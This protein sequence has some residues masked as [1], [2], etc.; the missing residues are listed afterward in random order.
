MLPVEQR[1]ILRRES[2]RSD[3]VFVQK[4]DNDLKF[5][6]TGQCE[7]ALRMNGSGWKTWLKRRCVVQ[8]QGGLGSQEPGGFGSS[9]WRNLEQWFSTGDKLF[10]WLPK[11]SRRILNKDQDGKEHSKNYSSG[12]Q[13][14][15]IQYIVAWSPAYAIIWQ[16]C[17]LIG[18]ERF[19]I[20]TVEA[21]D[22]FEVNLTRESPRQINPPLLLM[23]GWR[24]GS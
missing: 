8:N 6:T 17:V 18:G 24:K 21:C 2:H 23:S 20:E 3:N 12:A 4:P 7:Q 5:Q 14:S 10:C 22:P 16:N 13:K 15:M 1:Q 19:K 9:T 11:G